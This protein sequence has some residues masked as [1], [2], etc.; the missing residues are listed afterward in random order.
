MLG[1]KR[2]INTILLILISLDL[3]LCLMGV[4]YPST[5]LKFIHGVYVPDPQSLMIRLGIVW[6]TF[7]LIQM[8]ALARWEKHLYWLPL[9]AGVRLTESIADWFYLIT[10]NNVSIIGTI[11]LIFI[12]IANIGLG[13]ILI[14]CYKALSLD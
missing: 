11:I 9:V 6:G 12:P 3:F 2:F 10:A 4:V 7:A 8:I 5:W 13:V 1:S 14:L